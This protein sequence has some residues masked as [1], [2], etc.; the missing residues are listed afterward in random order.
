MKARRRRPRRDGSWVAY[1]RDGA[2]FS[3]VKVKLGAST[4]GLVSIESGLRAHDLVALR[5]P[6][7]SVDDILGAPPAKAPGGGR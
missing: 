7:Q 6:T 1:R 4:A 3:A 2:G 5:D